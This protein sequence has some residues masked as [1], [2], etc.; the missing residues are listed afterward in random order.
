M[1]H[2]HDVSKEVPLQCDASQSWVGAALLQE[3]QPVAF[4]SRALITTERNYARI[5]KELLVILHA[6]DRFHQYVF[7]RDINIETH[8][9]SLEKSLEN[10]F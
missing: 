6:C 7:R 5:E 2:Y 9:K 4:T 1:L 8:Y 10:L 3:G